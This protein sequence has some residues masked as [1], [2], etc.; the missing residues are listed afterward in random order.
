MKLWEKIMGFFNK[1]TSPAANAVSAGVNSAGYPIIT[2]ARLAKSGVW[3][4]NPVSYD[5]G[6]AG[7]SQHPGPLVGF[8]PDGTPVYGQS[9]QPGFRGWDP[10]TGRAIIGF[11][12]KA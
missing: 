2:D 3:T 7:Q 9:G 4:N 12:K 5:D 10:V 8:K 1:V 6:K 11:G